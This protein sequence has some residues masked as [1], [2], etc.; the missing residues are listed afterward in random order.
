MNEELEID[1]RIRRIL[2]LSLIAHLIAAWFTL[3]YHSFDEQYQILE[4]MSYKLGISSSSDLP[5]EYAEQVRPWFQPFFGWLIAKSCSIAG[6]SNP[7]TWAFILRFF[8]SLLG[9]LSVIAITNT[10]RNWY[11]SH[12]FFQTSVGILALLWFFPYLHAR[13]SSESWATSFFLIG[14]AGLLHAFKRNSVLFA[15]LSGISWGFAFQARYVVLV[16]MLSS[17]CWCFFNDRKPRLFLAG[18]TGFFVAMAICL[19]VDRWGYGQWTLPFWRYFKSNIVENRLSSF[20]TTPWWM[21][22]RYVPFDATFPFGWA[23][24]LGTFFGWF[25]FPKHFLTWVT[26]PF[27]LLHIFLGHKETRFL[28]PLAPF[29]VCL[30]MLCL[31]RF[32]NS[33]PVQ[34]LFSTPVSKGILFVNF[35]ML[36]IASV[37]PASAEVALM[38]F[39]YK[40]NSD[41]FEYYTTDDD[42]YK[43]YGLEAKF[44]EPR[45]L[46]RHELESLNYVPAPKK[47][48]KVFIV[49]RQF[50]L[51][52]K[53]SQCEATYRSIPSFVTKFNFGHWI[54]RTSLWSVFECERK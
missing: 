12:F 14:A 37:K 22:F 16:M 24:I 27:A 25:L 43:A 9:W 29:S 45:I 32:Q 33:K 20:G 11:R 48:E 10:C 35:V 31:E 26:L 4:F 13:P 52:V 5:W 7:F 44:Y 2:A 47:T 42:P 50:F 54:E 46:L 15:T 39:I 23:L 3:G 34:W 30:A 8:S 41:R 28:F 49:T 6:I 38:Q 18:I 53:L 40:N 36:T 21:Y 1:L 17:L 51:P 19:V